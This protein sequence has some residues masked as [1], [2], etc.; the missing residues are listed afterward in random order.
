MHIIQ[1][2]SFLYYSFRAALKWYVDVSF[3]FLVRS[4][5]CLAYLTIHEIRECGHL[6]KRKKKIY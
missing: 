4:W 1:I 6:E 5:N 2:F 3:E